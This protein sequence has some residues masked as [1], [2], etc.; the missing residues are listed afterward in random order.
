[1]KAFL[2]GLVAAAVLVAAGG[3]AVAQE[4]RPYTN[5]PVLDLS[6]IKVKPGMFDAYL[7]YLDTT[8]KQLMEAA[9]KDGAILDY[10]VYS[11]NPRSPQ[12]PDLVLVMR[13]KNMAAYDALEDRME[14]VNRQ[15]W[16]TREAANKADIGRGAM[17]EELGSEVMRELVLK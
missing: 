4:A 2:I 10:S 14:A 9:K 8:W 17:R 12:E 6:Y 11:A 16:P 1:M 5:G 3:H 15:V 7:H 13:L